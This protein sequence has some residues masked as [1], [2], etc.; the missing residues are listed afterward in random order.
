[1]SVCDVVLSLSFTTYNALTLVPFG[2]YLIKAG[3]DLPSSSSSADSAGEDD[4][5]DVAEA[6]IGQLLPT[7]EDH[8]VR[9]HVEVGHTHQ[10]V[11]AVWTQEHHLVQPPLE[12]VVLIVD[13]DISEDVILI[14]C[15]TL[16]LVSVELSS[17]LLGSHSDA[18]GLVVFLA[19]DDILVGEADLVLVV[20]AFLVCRVPVIVHVEPAGRVKPSAV[21]ARHVSRVDVEVHGVP[22]EV[23][24]LGDVQSRG[25]LERDDVPITQMKLVILQT[26]RLHFHLISDAEDALSLGV[27]DIAPLTCWEEVGVLLGVPVLICRCLN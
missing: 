18:D 15:G 12:H 8:A 17:K 7:A 20:G 25:V 10:V 19:I 26:G 16:G 24:G 22:L 11:G 23:L 3:V 2:L 27:E 21:G 13:V 6:D 9:V 4:L 1:M 14:D 5:L